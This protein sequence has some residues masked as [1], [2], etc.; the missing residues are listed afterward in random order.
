MA[1]LIP[2]RTPPVAGAPEVRTLAVADIAPNPYQPRQDFNVDAMTELVES[3]RRHGILQPLLVRPRGNGFE[4]VAGERRLRA[5]RA[6]G[7]ATVPAYVRDVDDRE[8]MEM[9]LVENLQR[10]DLNPIEEAQAYARLIQEFG[11]TQEDVAARV[12]RSRPQVANYLR[13]LHLEE[14]IQEHIRQGSLTV[15]HGKVLLTVDDGARRLA[16][17]AEA[18]R[19]GW[20]VKQ[21][22]AAVAHRAIPA[23]ARPQPDAHLKQIESELRR[24]F[25]T[26]VAL[27]GNAQKG[28][29]EI[30]YRTLEELER[31][32]SLLEPGTPGEDGFVV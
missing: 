23:P 9:A 6:V 19:Q 20:T 3:V 28:R 10:A 1:A 13:I 14:A 5:A 11:W 7:L 32:L 31:I 8:V 15:A 17:A 26:R 4:L 22:E 2:E 16:L 18:V 27:R 24:R 21:L 25:G 29:I 12:G 30:P